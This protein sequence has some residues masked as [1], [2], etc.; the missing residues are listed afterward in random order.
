VAAVKDGDVQG[1]AAWLK[2]AGAF[3]RKIGGKETGAGG[4]QIA[5]VVNVNR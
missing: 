5:L 4:S 1:S 3:D 2:V